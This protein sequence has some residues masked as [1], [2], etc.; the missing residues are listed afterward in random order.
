MGGT[1]SHNIYT[2]RLVLF[3]LGLI[4]IK[5]AGRKESRTSEINL[6]RAYAQ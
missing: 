5:L 6:E 2:L 3:K 1:H 4:G